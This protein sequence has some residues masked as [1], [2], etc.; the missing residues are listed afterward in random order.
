M[1]V[2]EIGTPIVVYA[3]VAG[4]KSGNG[5]AVILRPGEQYVAIRFT[6]SHALVQIPG[7]GS[8]LQVEVPLECVKTIREGPFVPEF[9]AAA[10]D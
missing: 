2:V 6:D 9:E 7:V 5:T 10:A 1:I 3:L 8:F 4:S